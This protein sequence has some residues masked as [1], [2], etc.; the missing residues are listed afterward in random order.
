MSQNGKK[1]ITLTFKNMKKKI[2]FLNIYKN[3]ENKEL[4]FSLTHLGITVPT[5]HTLQEGLWNIW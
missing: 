1:L 5:A 4:E 3:I 2:D